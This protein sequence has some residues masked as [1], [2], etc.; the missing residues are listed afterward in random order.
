M[1]T[2]EEVESLLKDIDREEDWYDVDVY[3]DFRD[4]KYLYTEDEI[5]CIEKESTII[6]FDRDGNEYS[7]FRKGYKN[8]SYDRYINDTWYDWEIN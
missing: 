1:L 4:F 3:K 8:F 6:I 2:R 5:D 7:A